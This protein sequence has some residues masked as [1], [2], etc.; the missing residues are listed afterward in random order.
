MIGL[1]LLQQVD[2]VV[3]ERT[4][5]FE[6]QRTDRVCHSLEEV[7]LPMGEVVHGIDA[8][9]RPRPMVRYLDDAVDDGVTEVH[10]RRS[11]IDLRS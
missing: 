6:L 11:H 1:D 8:P 2:E 10:I 3:V 9:L 5:H 7:T 4:M